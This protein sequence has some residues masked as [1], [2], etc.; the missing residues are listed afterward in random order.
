LLNIVFVLFL[1]IQTTEI[2]S[3]DTHLTH[4]DTRKTD[5]LKSPTVPFQSGEIGHG[6]K[7]I[8]DFSFY[9]F[10]F[11]VALIFVFIQFNEIINGNFLKINFHLNSRYLFLQNRVLLI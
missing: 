5:F 9:Q 2:T 3:I 10:S 11:F 6:N 7:S 4:L 1:S 8:N